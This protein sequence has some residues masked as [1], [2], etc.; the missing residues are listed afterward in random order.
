V[1]K[2]TDRVSY[3][4]L[5]VILVCLALFFFPVIS[6]FTV[7][8]EAHA[9]QQTGGPAVDAAFPTPGMGCPDRNFHGFPGGPCRRF[10]P[11]GFCS[12][13]PTQA[14]TAFPTVAP[15]TAPTVAPSPTPT[16]APTPVPT[17]A[18]VVPASAGY[19][20]APTPTPIPPTP[21]P[22]PT[23]TPLTVNQT[24][25][26]VPTT[27]ASLASQ[28]LYIN[29]T[30][31]TFDWVA[32]MIVL[33]ALLGIGGIV[34]VFWRRQ[35]LQK[36]ASFAYDRDATQSMMMAPMSMNPNQSGLPMSSEFPTHRQFLE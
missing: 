7:T 10:C 13:F 28:Q 15:T 25:V 2:C 17:R 36:M 27:S 21:T 31:T 20:P 19:S 5:P 6:V 26:A 35:R 22:I 9:A 32:F 34:F 14:P 11:G 29:Q 18:P 30:G 23:P 4:K 3:R 1:R 33:F 12:T 16:V 8:T 24:P